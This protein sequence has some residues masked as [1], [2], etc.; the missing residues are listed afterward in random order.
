M[1]PENV[2]AGRILFQLFPDTRFLDP[3][4]TIETSFRL[5][6]NHPDTT[7]EQ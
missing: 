4:E 2:G 7:P 3:A 5:K 6:R 1:F